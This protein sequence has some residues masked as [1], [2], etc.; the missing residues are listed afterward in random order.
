MNGVT[1]PPSSA[2]GKR[3]QPAIQ[4]IERM[5]SVLDALAEQAEP[6][7]LKAIAERCGL[8]PSTAH[9]ILNDL[10]TGHLVDRCEPGVY[11][12]GM[13]LLEL[14]NLVRSRI[15]VR[16]LALPVMRELHAQTGETANL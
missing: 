8:H 13:R 10:A 16:E 1:K 2:A 6:V 14:G 4:V 3:E 15:S 9:R 7:P 11:Q 5:F 12:L